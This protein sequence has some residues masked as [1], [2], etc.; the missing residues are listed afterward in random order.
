MRVLSIVSTIDLAES[1]GC[2]PA[3][4]QLHKA[5]HEEGNEMIVIPYLGRD[6]ESPWWRTHE[7][8]CY[9]ESR[10]YSEVA[11]RL[12]LTAGGDAGTAG[13]VEFLTNNWTKRKWKQHLDEVVADEMPDIVLFF[14][15]PL[16]QIS[17]LAS[18][19]RQEHGVPVVYYDGDLPTILPEHVE[20]RGFL[21][22]YYDNA[23]LT[24]YDGFV[25]NSEGVI[26]RLKELGAR[27]VHP[28]HYAA[29]PGIYSPVD[30]PTEYDVAFFGIGAAFREKHIRNM[31]ID[32]AHE[33]VDRTFV[34][35]GSGWEIDLGS[36]QR[37]GWVPVNGFREFAG[38]A[39]I[40][41]NITRKG[42]REVYKSSTSRPFELAAMGACVVSDPYNGL[43]DWFD[44][45]EEMF[46]A[47]SK[48]NAIELY[49]WLLDDDEERNAIGQRARARVLEEHTFNHRAKELEGTLSRFT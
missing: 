18:W 32:P 43:E 44:I 14:N 16:N 24:E 20:S 21:F 17:G 19:L 27:E 49:E 13:I 22:D 37:T 31:L 29:D 7:N 33:L 4:W 2:T 3:W 36:V 23:D 40:N 46:V 38:R 8:P 39:R 15:V 5:L 6:I 28:I 12:D 9:W 42:H 41:L 10:L 48:E 45:G 30:V 47:N 11:D 35:G 26:D 1:L 34:V 25:V